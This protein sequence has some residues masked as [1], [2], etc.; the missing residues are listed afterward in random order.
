[1]DRK[2][3]K[4]ITY[5]IC[6]EI[7]V[8]CGIIFMFGLG[9]VLPMPFIPVALLLAGFKLW[10]YIN[11]RDNK[12]ANEPFGGW[13]PLFETFVWFWIAILL[14]LASI[15]P[16]IFYPVAL[17]LM[18]F[19]L[20][21][22]AVPKGSKLNGNKHAGAHTAQTTTKVTQTDAD[23]VRPTN[24]AILGER[25]ATEQRTAERQAVAEQKPLADY[26]ATLDRNEKHAFLE[27]K[28]GKNAPF[29]KQRWKN[30]EYTATISELRELN[31][32]IADITISDKIDRIE[33][34]SAKIF[35]IVEENP[36]KLPAIRRF[37]D[38]YLPTTLKLLH[39]YATLEK[40]G[41]S[42]ENTT[43]AK[44]RID[45]GLDILT[46]CYEQ[47]LDQLFESDAL[48]IDTDIDVLE[49]MMKQDG[50]SDDNPLR[51]AVAAVGSGLR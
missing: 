9:S 29:G 16:L 44:E 21:R 1:M 13:S 22:Y 42:G 32:T 14:M 41:D 40:Q 46:K 27:N 37:M 19:K 20:W 51:C 15:S 5:K 39:S 17:P 25:R 2:P 30:A 4:P 50:L 49:S 24:A 43:Y 12:H 45:V 23:A 34:L 8:W 33:E 6:T 7:Y 28:D 35:C 11:P 36:A 18:V 31:D 38:Y 47:Q 26:R 48:D 3:I 10:L